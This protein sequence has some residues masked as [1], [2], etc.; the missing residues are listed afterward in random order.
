MDDLNP[1]ERSRRQERGER[2][3][4]SQGRVATFLDHLLDDW[5]ATISRPAP[6]P[7]HAANGE[8]TPGLLGYTGTRLD[9][10]LERNLGSRVIF[11]MVWNGVLYERAGLLRGYSPRFL[12]LQDVLLPQE[13]EITLR[14]GEQATEAAGVRLE[15]AGNRLS[16]TNRSPYPLLLDTLTVGDQGHDVGMALAAGATFGAGLDVRPQTRCTLVCRAVAKVDLIAPRQ[17]AVVRYRIPPG[18]ASWPLRHWRRSGR[19]WTLRTGGTS[20]LGIAP[21]S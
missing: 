16:I 4:R 11:H 9:P 3:G 18:Q 20:A 2:L 19:R 12:L 21:A 6:A 1:G 17:R 13:Q 15:L 5:R 14:P 10:M 7:D 8:V